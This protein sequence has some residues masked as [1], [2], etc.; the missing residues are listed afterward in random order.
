MKLNI[1]AEATTL[2]QQNYDKVPSYILAVND[3]TNAFSSSEGCCMIGDRFLLQPITEIIEPYTV[4]LSTE[5]FTV[6][7]AA[8]DQMFLSGD[9]TL[10]ISPATRNLQLNDSRGIVDYNVEV[11]QLLNQISTS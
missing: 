10:S 9:L 8:Y 4:K 6:Y 3:G 1:T 11:K 5:P 2:L 7:T